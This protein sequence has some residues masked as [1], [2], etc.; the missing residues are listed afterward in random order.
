L[1]EFYEQYFQGKQLNPLSADH[2]NQM[3]RELNQIFAAF[4]K[5]RRRKESMPC[6]SKKFLIVHAISAL[7]TI[8][9]KEPTGRREGCSVKSLA[10]RI[11]L[12]KILDL[13][14]NQLSKAVIVYNT[15]N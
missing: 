2:K 4:P 10:K 11:Y 8:D 1:L 12:K 9:R 13:F 3:C 5:E 14:N 15:T 7:K 6:I